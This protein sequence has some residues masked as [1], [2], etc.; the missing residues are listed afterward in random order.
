MV[1]LVNKITHTFMWVADERLEK[2]LE[3]GHVLASEIN[4]EPDEVADPEPKPVKKAT[5]R[6]PK[7]K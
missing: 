4:A 6:A 7:K 2:Y 1:K 5:K 3:A